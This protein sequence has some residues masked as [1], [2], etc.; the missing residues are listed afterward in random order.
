[1]NTEIW[2][3]QCISQ[4]K[5]EDKSTFD[6]FTCKRM[7][8]AST[9]GHPFIVYGPSFCND[10]DYA[11]LLQLISFRNLLDSCIPLSL[12]NREM[13]KTYSWGRALATPQRQQ[14]IARHQSRQQIPI[15]SGGEAK[16]RDPGI[17]G[18]KKHL[19]GGCLTIKTF[20]KNSLRSRARE[21][22]K[23]NIIP[24]RNP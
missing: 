21:S 13:T 6:Y 10:N 8:T 22:L 23:E 12:K 14:A 24:G 5:Y 7:G 11:I 2:N 17:S 19:T 9:E 20:G 4:F 16:A 1:M 18:Y 15:S 3:T